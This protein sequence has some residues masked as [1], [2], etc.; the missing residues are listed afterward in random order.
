MAAGFSYLDIEL[1]TGQALQRYIQL[2]NNLKQRVILTDVYFICA[3]AVHLLLDACSVNHRSFL[4]FYIYLDL[5]KEK[6]G[7]T[8]HCLSI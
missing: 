8:T 3:R 1:K 7:I 5:K 2:P 4:A 6:E